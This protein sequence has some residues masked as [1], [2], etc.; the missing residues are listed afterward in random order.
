MTQKF[1]RFLIYGILAG[2]TLLVLNL[3]ISEITD[4]E[5][6]GLV[7]EN[8]IF[9]VFIFA[10]AG[11][12]LVTSAIVYT[13]DRLNKMQ[14]VGIHFAAAACAFLVV[15]FALNLFYENSPSGIVISILISVFLFSVVW[16]VFY[17]Y[18]KHEANAINEA[19]R[20]REEQGDKKT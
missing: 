5:L 11:I 1:L 4:T 15:A 2:N 12:G 3:I 18:G 19:L 14:Q 9:N 13:F 20:K 17:F 10:I 8:F 16:V 6:I 7:F